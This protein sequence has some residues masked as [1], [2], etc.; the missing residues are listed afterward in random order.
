MT[1][2]GDV[3]D[4]L[5]I[6]RAAFAARGIAA[7]A[8]RIVAIVVQPGVELDHNSVNDFVPAHDPVDRI[9]RAFSFSDRIRYYWPAPAVAAA[10]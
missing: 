7:A 8:E 4:I 9:A 6:P 5:A 3:A 10:L 2:P 1:R